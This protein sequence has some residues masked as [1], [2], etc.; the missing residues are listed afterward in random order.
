[1]VKKEKTFAPIV[2]NDTEIEQV[3]FIK[4][5]GLYLSNDLTWN[6][7]IETITAKASSAV[8]FISML[9]RAAIPREELVSIYCTLVRPLLEYA[10]PIWHSSLPQY[11]TDSIEAI[12]RRALRIIYPNTSYDLAL[13]ISNIPTL[14]TLT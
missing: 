6:L 10:C 13:D 8:Y 12:Q 11:L 1:M 7:H 9:K 3:E 14:P 4:C 5:L 2:I